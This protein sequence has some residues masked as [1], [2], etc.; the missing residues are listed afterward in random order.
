M[1]GHD[2]QMNT[3]LKSPE[4]RFYEV[5]SRLVDL[6]VNNSAYSIEELRRLDDYPCIACE[7]SIIKKQIGL[8]H[9]NILAENVISVFA[10]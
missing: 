1:K 6:I 2:Q 9:F 10:Q 7:L 8:T 3:T 4:E 5:A